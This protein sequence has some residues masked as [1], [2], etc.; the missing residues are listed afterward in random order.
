MCAKAAGSARL[1]GSPAG[2]ARRPGVWCTRLGGAARGGAR[3]APD[4][5]APTA[6][7]PRVV[8]GGPDSHLPQEQIAALAAR[9]PHGRLVTIPAGHLIHAVRPAEFIAVVRDFLGES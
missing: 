3:A 9:I 1:T 6:W 4:L 7:N 5:P 2:R 8:A